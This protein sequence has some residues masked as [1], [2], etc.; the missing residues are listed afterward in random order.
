VLPVLFTDPAD[1]ARAMS[2]WVTSTA[3]G[4]P[5]GPI[6]GGWLIDNFWWGSVFLIGVPVMLLLL[7]LGPRTLP[8]Y[9]DPNARRLDLASAAMSLL[10]ILSVVYGLKQIAQDGLSTLPVVTIVVGLLLG[11]V[12]VWRQLRIESPLIDVHIFRIRALNASLATYLLSIFVVVGY[13]LFIA[14]YLQLVLGLSPLVAA[15]LELPS[16][17]GFIVGSTLSPWLIRRY[18][19]AVIMGA[20]LG[21][22]AVGSV[23]FIGLTVDGGIGSLVLLAVASLVISVGLAPVIALAT[24]LI[25]G[26]APPEQAGSATGVSETSAE[27][28]GALG[29]AILGSIGTALYRAEVADALPAGIS[30]EVANA[31]R[32]T[33]GGALTIAQG[34]PPELG[35]TVV[36]AAQI[37]FVDALHLVAIVAAVGAVVTAIAAAVV[38]WR[39]P[40]RSDAPRE[41]A[42]IATAL[43]GE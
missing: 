7:I 42:P 21:I 5:L 28:G 13:F 24:E 2:I 34:L 25:V 30:G 15:F 43:A 33:L 17:A 40:V 6:L 8:E 1:R 11:L 37:A 12:F 18:R 31:A 35:A 36:A 38:M 3:L 14:Q 20:G 29:I 26:S 32:D 41:E 22:S 16:A 10:A 23:M 27:L 39:V 9:R 19:P 4:L